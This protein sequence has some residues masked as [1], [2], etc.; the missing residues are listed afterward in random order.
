MGNVDSDFFRTKLLVRRNLIHKN[1]S[2]LYFSSNEDLKSLFGYFDFRD[3]N[4]LSVVGSGDQAFHFINKGVT[5]IDLY[6]KNKLSFYYF[7]LRMWIIDYYNSFYPEYPF[8]EDYFYKLFDHVNLGSEEEENALLYWKKCVD[9]FD[10]KE[11]G[12]MFFIKYCR[13]KNVIR[14]VTGLNSKIKNSK[15]R[16][17]NCDISSDI[18][19]DKTYDVIFISNIIDHLAN[20]DEVRQFKDNLLSLLN[21][22]GIIISSKIFSC[23]ISKNEQEVF[24][25][26]FDIHTLILNDNNDICTKYLPGYYYVKKKNNYL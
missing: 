8:S 2:Y 13:S 23:D 12:R 3:M 26:D 24:C 10:L 20:I 16:L 17:Y 1:H 4:V 19:F 6:D 7:Y 9:E 11:I 15:Y 5:S 18:N 21:D 25:D 22:N 14:N